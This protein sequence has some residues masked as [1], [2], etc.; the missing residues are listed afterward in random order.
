MSLEIRQK[1]SITKC[2]FEEHNGKHNDSCPEVFI[3]T[4][5]EVP[6]GIFILSRDFPES[7]C[8]RF[9]IRKRGKC[10]H[11]LWNVRSHILQLFIL[12]MPLLSP[13]V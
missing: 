5:I 13:K 6:L 11:K 10:S 12:V 9:I 2:K 4:Y 3:W 7:V 1:Q 8:L